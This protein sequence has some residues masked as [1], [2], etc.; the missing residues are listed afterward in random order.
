MNSFA[1]KRTVRD[2]LQDLDIDGRL[3]IKWV[4]N[5]IRE[6]DLDQDMGM[7]QALPEMNLRVPLNTG[8]YL[9]I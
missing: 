6:M 9:N 2:Q 7:R 3:T 1:H 5:K 4:L 8:N